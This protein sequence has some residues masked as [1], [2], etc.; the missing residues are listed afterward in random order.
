MAYD[1]FSNPASS[2]SQRAVALV[3]VVASVYGARLAFQYAANPNIPLPEVT[4]DGSAPPTTEQPGD[5]EPAVGPANPITASP[6]FP[7]RGVDPTALRAGNQTSLEA[8]RIANQKALIL[9]GTPRF[10]PIVVTRDG[11]VID[12]A[13]AVRAAAE[14]G[15]TVD[16]VVS[17]V[18]MTPGP[19][20]I[21]LPI[22]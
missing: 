9:S 14:L 6:G 10:D 16:V 21:D 18:N 7:Q 22:R 19:P 5:P 1:V 13:H 15:Q 8:S 17:P 4:L 3:M 12:G 2:P 20:I 11:V